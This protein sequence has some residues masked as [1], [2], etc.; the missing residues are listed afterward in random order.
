MLITDESILKHIRSTYKNYSDYSFNNSPLNEEKDFIVIKDIHE[1]NEATIDLTKDIYVRNLHSNRQ[2]NCGN[3]QMLCD[4]LNAEANGLAEEVYKALEN[5]NK[6]YT[7]AYLKSGSR[8]VDLKAFFVACDKAKEII[9]NKNPRIFFNISKYSSLI[10]K[11][12][13]KSSNT[14]LNIVNL[15]TLY[16]LMYI[17]ARK[18]NYDV[19]LQPVTTLSKLE[20]NVSK[21]ETFIVS[22]Y[23][24][25]FSLH[26]EMKFD[27]EFHVFGVISG[28]AVRKKGEFGKIKP[29]Y[30]QFRLVDLLTKDFAYLNLDIKIESGIDQAVFVN[31]KKIAHK[32]LL[33]RKLVNCNFS[34]TSKVSAKLLLNS[35]KKL[36]N[37]T[38]IYDASEPIELTSISNAELTN[39]IDSGEGMLVYQIDETLYDKYSIYDNIN[40]LANVVVEKGEFFDAK[41]NLFSVTYHEKNPMLNTFLDYSRHFLSFLSGTFQADQ[42]QRIKLFD[43]MMNQQ[44]NAFIRAEQA[45]NALEELR[46]SNEKINEISFD[47]RE[48]NASL[49]EKVAERTKELEVINEQKTNTFINLAHETKTPLTLINNYLEDYIYKHGEGEEI[50]IIKRNIEKLNNDIVNFFDLER[51]NKGFEIYDNHTI[52]NFSEALIESIIL[53]KP[54]CNKKEIQIIDNIEPNVFLECSPEGIHRIINNLLENSIKFTPARGSITVSLKDNGTVIEFV[55]KDT[56]TGISPELHSKIFEPYFQINT[57]KKSLQGMGLGLP[58]VSKIVTSLNGKIFIDSNPQKQTGTTFSLIFN[59]PPIIQEGLSLASAKSN[60]PVRINIEVLNAESLSYDPKK[61]TILIVEDNISMLNYLSKKLNEYYNICIAEN[62][63]EALKILKSVLPDLIIADVMMDKIDGFK[64]AKILQSELG[65]NLR[66]IPI[67]FL[68]ARSTQKDRIEGLKLGAI[69]FIQKPFNFQELRQKIESIFLTMGNQKLSTLAFI[70]NSINSS[71]KSIS[72]KDQQIENKFIH[73]CKTFQLTTREQEIIELI[74][75][76]NTYKTIGDSLNISEKT[77]AKHLQ[78]IFSKVNVTNK[79]ELINKL[80]T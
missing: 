58:L 20:D 9:G 7:K 19:F 23:F 66:S 28:L 33:K 31:N 6:S 15:R 64:F 79:I 1:I 30:Y 14:K 3:I 60:N 24:N 57:E 50:S 39:L 54:Y 70:S 80:E 62:G 68:S 42:V 75:K 13:L 36:P 41:Y 65:I 45:E 78:N 5:Y 40:P 72:N 34:S 25:N 71:N 44:K 55:V 69:D 26:T 48:L 46:K 67:I 22:K 74:S 4:S 17:E 29:Y 2:T 35:N 38:Y 56:G 59:T 73:N 43:S 37:D 53:F 18:S 52:I 63:S 77:V 21:L 61:K 27:H 12:L 49:Q 11:S 10:D 47:L 8:W 16:E 76:G 51:F 32:A